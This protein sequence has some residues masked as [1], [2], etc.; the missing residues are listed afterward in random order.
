M[1]GTE[2]LL[3][4]VLGVAFLAYVLNATEVEVVA[5]FSEAKPLGNKQEEALRQMLQLISTTGITLDKS[6]PL[7]H[8]NLDVFASQAT[9]HNTSCANVLR[10]IAG[11]E[12]KTPTSK[13]RILE[14]LNQ[15]AVESYSLFL[16]PRDKKT[17]DP[18]QPSLSGVTFM[19]SLKDE[20]EK[21]ILA[22][23][24]LVKLFGNENLDKPAIEITGYVH[25]SS[26]QGSSVQLVMLPEL[27]L[28]N[29]W[30]LAL[31][32][33]KQPDLKQ[34]SS[35]IKK[36]V[37]ILRAAASGKNVT[38]PVRVALTGIV[39]PE[40]KQRIELPWGVL[41]SITERDESLIPSIFADGANS[42]TT[43]NGET[44][45]IK[46][47]GDIILETEVPYRAFIADWKKVAGNALGV[48]L[49][50]NFNDYEIIQKR[51]EAVE[52]GLLFST[53]RDGERP[54]V[55]STWR[56][57]VDPLGFSGHAISWRNPHTLPLLL[58]ARL[59]KDEAEEW[60]RW[61]NIIDRKRVPSIEVAVHRLLLAGIE[62]KDPVDVLID[63]VIA[64]ENLVGSPS[65]EPTLR[66]S[67]ALAWLLGKDSSER[68]ELQSKFSKL[69]NLRSRIVHGSGV[70]EVNE[71]IKLPQEAVKI[72]LD[73]LKEIFENR[74]ELLEDCK[75]SNERSK[76]LILDT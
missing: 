21:A 61:I 8:L 3:L 22:D 5:R 9:G 68:A 39:L 72:A 73:A 60:K 54:R 59:T 53:N 52:I 66:V 42:T 76:K 64:W 19:H 37:H 16:I 11:G 57:E 7:W 25:R 40:G 44:V 26:G 71:S 49:P 1:A 6:S 12:I 13:D 48:K 24:A 15:L 35:A 45:T 46:Y 63:A 34:F 41:R 32:D 27:I 20:L 55:V 62:R 56:A 69:Y 29:A 75:D 51:I 10:T 14:I 17:P 18:F 31:L 47:S 74:P 23:K 38:I 50:E 30:H 67:S 2:S 33:A 36:T 65:G 70:L 28:R 43:S 4:E 58:P